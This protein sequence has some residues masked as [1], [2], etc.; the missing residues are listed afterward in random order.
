MKNELRLPP[1][2]FTRLKGS[3]L[4]CAGD[5][6]LMAGGAAIGVT[7]EAAADGVL[8]VVV[9]STSLSGLM[10]APVA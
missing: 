9:I 4:T 3:D 5:G 7:A 8:T 1:A 10:V 2:L 6:V